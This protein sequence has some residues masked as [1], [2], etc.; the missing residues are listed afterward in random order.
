[1]SYDLVLFRPK[2]GEDPIITARHETDEVESETPSLE[3]ANED[4]KFRVAEALMKENPL[5]ER[6]SF[7]FEEIAKIKNILS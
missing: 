7:D 4:L 5:L 6:F 3:T 1:M 2:Q